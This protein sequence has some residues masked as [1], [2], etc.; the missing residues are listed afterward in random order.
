MLV[1]TF[2]ASYKTFYGFN[3]EASCVCVRISDTRLART[4]LHRVNIAL[5][6][7][8]ALGRG[9]RGGTGKVAHTA[10]AINIISQCQYFVAGCLTSD[11]TIHPQASSRKGITH[12]A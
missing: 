4:K 11:V 1:Q 12:I 2:N 9:M 7:R 3:F 5:K 6:E 8:G 10:H